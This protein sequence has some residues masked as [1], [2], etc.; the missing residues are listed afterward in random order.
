MRSALAL[1]F[2]LVGCVQHNDP[3]PPGG[4]GGGGGY[5][6]PPDPPPTGYGCTADSQCANGQ[7]CA[8]T[9][10]C[11]PAAEGHVIHAGWTLQ[12]AAANQTSCAGAP[13]LEVD[14][15]RNPAN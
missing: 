4:G 5:Y 15:S 2:V 11:L 9:Y 8:R 10:D 12:G 1:A 3:Y 13:D 7:G 14:F 6:P